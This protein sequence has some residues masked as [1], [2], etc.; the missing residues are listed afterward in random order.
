MQKPKISIKQIAEL[1]NVSYPTVSRA[2][3]G[4]GRIGEN[5]RK[6]ILEIAQ[7]HGYTP[8]LT[9]RGLVSKRSGALG[10]VVTRFSDP[11]HSDIA[12][13]IEIEANRKG[14]S[15]FIAS[16]ESLDRE[17]E[18]EIVR[19]FQGRNVEGIVVSSGREGARYLQLFRETNIPIVT[20]NSHAEDGM[21]HSVCHDDFGGGCAIVQYLVKQGYE[22]VV[23]LG[24]SGAGKAQIDRLNA[25]RTILQKH[26][27]SVGLNVNSPEGKIQ[28]GASATEQ[29]INQFGSKLRERRS[30]IWCFNDAMAWGAL[31]VLHRHG[32]NVPNDIGVAGFDDIDTSAFAIPALTTWHQPRQEMASIA[33]QM[34]FAMIA[35]PEYP[36]TDLVM[37]GWL[38][39]RHST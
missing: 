27:L 36:P 31:A 4:E 6:R 15:L 26:G 28:N 10:L 3:R 22:Q 1:A 17:R 9:A 21:A 14:Y 24:N 30:A 34:I 5:T 13:K 39:P 33:A 8:N 2:L 11:F 38:V 7:N 20:I 23:Y 32:F 35:Q 12:E 37:S 29:L 19:S 16:N 25:W 18:L